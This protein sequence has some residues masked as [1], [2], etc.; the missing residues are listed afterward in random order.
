MKSNFKQIYYSKIVELITKI[1]RNEFQNAKPGHCMKITGLGADQLVV[2]WEELKKQFSNIDVFI[3]NEVEVEHCYISA[4]KLI[5]FRNNQQRPLLILIPANN[6][7]AAEDSYG[8][9]T[10]KEIALDNIEQE[11]LKKLISEI[12]SEFR[13]VIKAFD[14][15]VKPAKKNKFNYI[16]YLI[17]LSENNFEKE[18]FGKLLHFLELLPDLNLLQEVNQIRSRLTLNQDSCGL[19]GAFNKTLYDRVDNLKIE[20]DTI[21]KDIVNLFKKKTDIKT[22]ADLVNTIAENHPNLWFNNW[23]IPVLNFEEI[24]LEI[25][26]IRST[27]FVEEEGRKI[28]KAK[29]NANSNVVIRFK[30]TPPPNQVDD[31]K[32]FKVV[33]M[34][35]DG[36]A[37]IEINTL[38]KLSNTAAK[39]EYREAKIELNSN[40]L[41]EGSYFFKIIAEDQNGAILNHNDNFQSI[42]IQEAWE[43]EGKTKEAKDN[44]N[45]K[46]TSDTED[47]EYEIT[48]NPDKEEN[49]RKDKLNN[50]LQGH[51][52]FNIDLLKNGVEADFPFPSESSNIWLNDD[53][54]KVNSVFYIN[55]NSKHNYQV[56]ISSKL[57]L[58]QNELL[59]QAQNIG[60]V[61]VKLSN[62]HTKLGFENMEFIPSSLNDIVPKKL[63][64]ARDNIFKKITASNTTNNGI[65]ETANIAE[66]KEDIKEYLDLYNK[67][68]SDLN[69][70]ISKTDID[71]SEQD[72]L[73]L[74]YAEIQFLDLVKVKTKL[75]NNESVNAVL[76]SPLHPLRLAWFYNLMEVF[77]N[78][79]EKSLR[80]KDHITEWGKLQELFLGKVHPSN[81]PFVIVDPF[82]F[83][84]YEYA[85]ELTLGW[86]I[87]FNADYLKGN[88]NLVPV[89]HQ[90]KQYYKTLLNITKDNYSDNEVSKTLLVK[91]L[92]NF[93][94]QHPY[95]DKLVINLF[96][97]GDADK[98]ADAFVELGKTSEYQDVKF[99]IRIFVGN[100]SLIEPGNALKELINPETNISEEAELFSQAS[101]NR[102]F[103]KL[104]FSINEIGDFLVTPEE[105]NAHLSFLVNPFN[106]KITL[107]KPSTEYKSDCLNG[108][109]ISNSTEVNI[110]KEK[111]VMRWVNYIDVNKSK[112]SIATNLFTNFQKNIAC[113]LASHNTTSLPAIQLEL[114]DRDKVLIS[115]LHEYSDWVVTFDKNLGPQIF[116]QPSTDTEI[117][118]LLDYIPSE[119][120]TGIS[121]YLTTKPSSEIIGLLSPHFEEFGLDTDTE[122]GVLCIKT[123]LEDVRAISSS[124]VLQLNSSKNKAFEVIGSAFSKRVLQKKGLLENAF[125]VPIDLHQ[126]LFE[127]LSSNSKSRADNLIV[128]IDPQ[129]R[130]INIAVLEIKCRAF[131]SHA[132]RE[133]LKAKIISQIENTILALKTHFDPNDFK[134][135]DRL[136]REIK[137]LDLKRIFQFYIERAKRYQY[138]S[139]NAYHSYINFMQTL[140]E[141]FKLNFNKIGFIFDF[142]FDK[143]H[144]KQVDDDN[145]TIFTFGH[146]LIKEI[147]DANSD[148]NTTRL[149]DNELSKELANSINVKDKLKPFLKKFEPKLKPSQSEATPVD[150]K[151]YKNEE[152]ELAL[153]SETINNGDST[154]TIHNTNTVETAIHLNG[155]HAEVGNLEP[156]IVVES[157][158]PSKVH[159][160]LTTSETRT[161]TE[162]IAP[163]F[164]IM[165]GKSSPSNQYGLIGTSI[166]SKKIAI[167]LSETNTIS[168]FGVQGGG[169]SYTIGTVSE[170]VLKE[171][172]NVNILKNPLAAVIFHYSES[173]DYEPEFTSMIYENNEERELAILKEKYGANPASIKDVVLLT[174]ADKLKERKRE[175]PSIE[176]KPIAFNSQELNVQDWMFLL[177]AIGNDSAYIRQLKMIMRSQRNNLSLN[178]LRESV[179]ESE[180]L[181]SSQKALARQKL[182]FAQE[183][184]DDTIFMRDTIKPGR[185]IIVDLRDE[186]IVKDEALGLFV[187]MLNI[188][189][190]VKEYNNIPFNKF[191]VFDEAHKYMDNK[192][193]TNNIVIAIREMRHKGVNIMIASQDPPSL[194]NEIIELSSVVLVHKFNSPQWLKHIQKSINQLSNLTPNDLSMLKPGEGF[195]WASKATENSI[196]NTP[197]KINT[198]PRFTKHGGA[199]LKADRN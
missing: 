152:K 141:G 120:I 68:L 143:K 44:L 50:V 14:D 22:V 62:N 18:Y 17:G 126:E 3:I 148:L 79:Q 123:L 29:E 159:S 26:E 61:N 75:P 135:E 176:I 199:T 167:D 28:L 106:S 189:S 191:I 136:D 102:L 80:Y 133:E 132:D 67:W 83:D 185:L 74:V 39:Q 1:H 23:K 91:H 41:E 11:L 4:T 98:F 194:P 13:A 76:L 134:S 122:E 63:V 71:T 38:R 36:Y 170:M 84:N 177:G 197:L 165:I 95:T 107:I 196:T 187:I 70:K 53:K 121:S 34:A 147:L 188:F 86:G 40:N 7:T 15:I 164:D 37:G 186:F 27:D 100:I 101:E 43:K 46:L 48:E 142:S 19:L 42:Q 58:I 45:F 110:D 31:L 193:L 85:G 12:P 175:F 88:D 119:D 172:Q 169:K 6:R 99:E 130:T 24:K 94:M 139:E 162:I 64:S 112:S 168:L 8:N 179:E 108:V 161:G 125:I 81:N 195:I 72:K 184:I 16:L 55:Y 163:E 97:V 105:Y 116:D 104:R 109:L 30:T 66:F 174:P 160:N 111:D 117:P 32:F 51:F 65:F 171:V 115:H 49:Q 90:L 89:T 190:S 155:N 178:G 113:T 92:K 140:N 52:K 87:Y 156:A 131:I 154:Y 82:N 146:S 138:L 173:M 9:A 21:Q 181:T 145:T 96:N 33:L 10:F 124:L 127:N 183:Y 25:L 118:F 151:I 114:N 56:I 59:K 57:R 20:K 150:P 5:E 35:V 157:T 182:N 144:L 93:L 73:K 54:P 166:H 60:Y 103:P 2:L 78:W 137:N 158:S 128:T 153:A 192:D 129:T 198:R 47:F 180:L 149:E 77:D 69:K